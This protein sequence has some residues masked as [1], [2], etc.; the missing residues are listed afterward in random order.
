MPRP[1][2]ANPKSLVY[3]RILNRRNPNAEELVTSGEL[4]WTIRKPDGTLLNLTG[5]VDSLGGAVSYLLRIR[6]EAV[7][8]GQTPVS[9]TIPL[10]TTLA[11]AFHMGITLNG[12][13][14]LIVPPSTSAFR[15]RPAFACQRPAP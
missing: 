15:C 3:G 12:S 13:P 5:D 11:T 14:A 7:M 10:G 2:S 1:S 4:R 6:T 8:L 9:G